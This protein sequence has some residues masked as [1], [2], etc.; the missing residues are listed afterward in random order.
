MQ[1]GDYWRR[2]NA[3][4]DAGRPAASN[5]PLFVFRPSGHAHSLK[6]VNVAA[7]AF[8]EQLLQIAPILGYVIPSELTV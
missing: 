5:T 8:V 4:F 2:R 3:A 1:F 6:I 7:L